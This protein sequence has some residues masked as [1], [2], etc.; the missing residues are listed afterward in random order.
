MPSIKEM[1]LAQCFFTEIQEKTFFFGVPQVSNARQGERNRLP[2]KEQREN[3]RIADAELRG[4]VLK[5][6]TTLH[7]L[8][9]PIL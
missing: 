5:R 9:P 8:R 3:P 1:P 6:R 2:D 7:A 4:K